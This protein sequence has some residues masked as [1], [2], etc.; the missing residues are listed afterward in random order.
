MNG[1]LVYSLVVGSVI[2]GGSALLG[3][4]GD[5]IESWWNGRR[6]QD[7]PPPLVVHLPFPPQP[8]PIPATGQFENL[9]ADDPAAHC[10]FPTNAAAAAAGGDQ[11]L[12]RCACGRRYRWKESA[13]VPWWTVVTGEPLDR[14]AI[15]V[16]GDQYVWMSDSPLRP[17][18]R[19]GYQPP[20]LLTLPTT[21]PDPLT[22]GS[23]WLEDT[24]RQAEQRN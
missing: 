11:I 7:K 12:W 19:A 13:F 22:D 20:T 24:I 21:T 6:N 16:D 5:H 8:A 4:W 18:H 1:A 15:R 2:V 9:P 17:T 23:D 14:T 3:L 10:P